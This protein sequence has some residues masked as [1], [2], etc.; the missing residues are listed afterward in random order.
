MDKS[1]TKATRLEVTC[2]WWQI[3]LR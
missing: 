2:S 1:V 3:S